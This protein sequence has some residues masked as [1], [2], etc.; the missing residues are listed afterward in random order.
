MLS[1]PS[2]WNAS[3]M[4]GFDNSDMGRMRL[5]NNRRWIDVCWYSQLG[6]IPVQSFRS[7]V[8]IEFSVSSYLSSWQRF[9]PPDHVQW[10]PSDSNYPKDLISRMSSYW[11]RFGL[12]FKEKMKILKIFPISQ[13]SKCRKQGPDPNITG[14]FQPLSNKHRQWSLG[15]HY[16][17]CTNYEILSD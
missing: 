11:N 2:W 7:K 17:G 13:G 6:W 15:D 3:T 10:G 9:I 4:T 5:K 8:I 16:A 12:I 1:S 14:V